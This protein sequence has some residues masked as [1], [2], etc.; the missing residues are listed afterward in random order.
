LAWWQTSG[1]GPWDVTVCITVAA[2]YTTAASQS[3]EAIVAEQAAERKSLKYAELTASYEF[4]PV[5]VETH[6]PM[7]KAMISFISELGH[8]ISKL[9]VCTGTERRESRKIRG[10]GYECYVSSLITIIMTSVSKNT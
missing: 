2:S 7:D 10:Y 6:G 5:A 9:E 8:K 1:L 3:A 4:Q